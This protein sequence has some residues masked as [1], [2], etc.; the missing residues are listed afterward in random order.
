[1]PRRAACSVWRAIRFW[2]AIPTAAPSD[3]RRPT[4][5]I[6]PGEVQIRREVDGW[7]ICTNGLAGVLVNHAIIS[8]EHELRSGD[9]VR[10]SIRGPDFQFIVQSAGAPPLEQIAAGYSTAV[11][12]AHGIR[13][14]PVMRLPR[15]ASQR[16]PPTSRRRRIPICRMLTPPGPLQLRLEVPWHPLRRVRRSPLRIPSIPARS[17][18]SVRRGRARSGRSGKA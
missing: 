17:L 12:K 1:M 13:P 2:S 5:R 4:S 16:R 15:R 11:A 9:L 6:W 18:A 10:L 14:A 3:F 7:R 8:G